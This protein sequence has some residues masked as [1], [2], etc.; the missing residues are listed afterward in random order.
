MTIPGTLSFASFQSVIE[1]GNGD[2][3]PD[4]CIVTGVIVRGMMIIIK[5]HNVS[6][7]I[8]QIKEQ[9]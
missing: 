7:H 6:D 4:K 3:I 9:H 8:L 2:F 1:E 5:T